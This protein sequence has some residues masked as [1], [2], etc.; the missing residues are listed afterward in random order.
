MGPAPLKVGDMGV[1]N[2]NNDADGR[3]RVN[4]GHATSL[5][6]DK[7]LPPALEEGTVVRSLVT[8][9]FWTPNCPNTPANAW[10]NAWA[11]A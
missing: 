11:N 9:S 5:V 2:K 1:L 7:E 4:F 3:V 10:A 6:F 8:A